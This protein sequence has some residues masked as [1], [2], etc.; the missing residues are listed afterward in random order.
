MQDFN[1]S[2]EQEAFGAE[3]HKITSGDR[4]QDVLDIWFAA[5]DF[6]D[7]PT[8]DDQVETRPLKLDDEIKAHMRIQILQ[9]FHP[10]GLTSPNPVEESKNIADWVFG[11]SSS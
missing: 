7:K 10:R 11:E 2:D 9:L 3:A 5:R 4:K 1:T 6:F 8:G